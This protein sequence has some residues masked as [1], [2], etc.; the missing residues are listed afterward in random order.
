MNL[1]KIEKSEFIISLF[2]SFHFVSIIFN[3]SMYFNLGNNCLFLILYCV[4]ALLF[5][6]KRKLFKGKKVINLYFITLGIYILLSTLLK[7]DTFETGFLNSYFLFLSILYTLIFIKFSEYSY[8]ILFYSFVLGTLICSSVLL[9][10]HRSPYPN[11]TYPGEKYRLGLFYSHSNYYDINFTAGLIMPITIVIWYLVINCKVKIKKILFT[12]TAIINTLAIIMISSRAAILPLLS[13]ICFFIV[14]YLYNTYFNKKIN[15]DK[16]KLVII[17]SLISVFAIVI[18]MLPSDVS[19]RIFRIDLFQSKRFVDWRY[20]FETFLDHPFVGNGLVSPYILIENSFN[21]TNYTAH[22]TFLIF[23]MQLGLLG[24]ILLMFI[25]VY[26]I[27]FLI[28]HKN[29]HN[30]CLLI[31]YLAFL[32]NVLFIE[33]NTSNIFVI[34]LFMFYI[35]IFNDVNLFKEVGGLYD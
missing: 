22:N 32:L 15:F 7:F 19:S 30:I 11:S 31:A 24:S 3:G 34:N 27:Y 6:F 14:L 28:K 26:P 1:N 4:F 10:Q 5:V 29:A 21:V 13:S 25:F 8:K 12:I 17:L 23:L 2:L 18:L 20:G 35:L 16:R 33:A 9:I